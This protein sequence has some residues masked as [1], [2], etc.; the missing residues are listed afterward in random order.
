[1]RICHV[2][3]LADRGWLYRVHGRLNATRFVQRLALTRLWGA[4]LWPLDRILLR[5]T[6]GRLGTAYPVTT[7]LLETRGARTGKPRA[8]AVI[9]FH[10]GERV[11]IVASHAGRPA[12]PAWYYNACANP[13]VTFGGEPYTA[14]RVEDPETLERLWALAA[15]VFPAFTSYRA[16][17]ERTGRTIPILA[18]TPT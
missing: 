16:V 8:T 6:G 4:V 10:D 2:D 11:I 3:P 17:A 14:A 13:D 7:A 9:Y 15:R 1:M 18:L 12:N 5:L